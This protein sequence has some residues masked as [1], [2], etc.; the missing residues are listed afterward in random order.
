MNVTSFDNTYISK[1][2]TELANKKLRFGFKEIVNFIIMEVKMFTYG[3]RPN[4]TNQ[5]PIKINAINL[6]IIA[7][8]VITAIYMLIMDTIFYFDK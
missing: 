4:E 2:F 3:I 5:M 7:L 8:I 1:E 6:Q